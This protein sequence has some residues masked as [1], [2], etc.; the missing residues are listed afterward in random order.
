MVQRDVVVNGLPQ[1]RGTVVYVLPG[2]PLWLA[3]GPGNLAPLPGT[4]TGDD[5]DHVELGN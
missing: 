1:L 2:S 3:Y 4:Q 5:A